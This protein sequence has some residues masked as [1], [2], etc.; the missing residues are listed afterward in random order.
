MDDPPHHRVYLGALT[1]RGWWW[2]AD[3][4]VLIHPTHP[5]YRVWFDAGSG[6]LGFSGRMSELIVERMGMG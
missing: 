4:R 6:N 3:R 5:D 2:S 1:R